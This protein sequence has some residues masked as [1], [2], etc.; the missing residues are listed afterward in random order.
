MFWG[1]SSFHLCLRKTEVIT[2]AKIWHQRGW[3]V[4]HRHK[5][6]CSVRWTGQTLTFRETGLKRAHLKC[7][8]TGEEVLRGQ[9]GGADSHTF[10]EKTV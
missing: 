8:N 1:K 9:N 4:K 3:E 10:S 5:Q 2:I 6:G 7:M